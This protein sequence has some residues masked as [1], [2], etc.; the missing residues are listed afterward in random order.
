MAGHSKWK[1]IQHRKNSQDAKRGKIYQKLSKEIFIAAKNGDNPETN[2]AL[3]L[4]IDKAKTQSMPKDN[5]QRAIDKAVGSSG[6]ENYEEIIYEG[7]GPNGIAVMVFCLTDNRNRTAANVRS[8]FAK[9]GGNLGADGSVAYLFQR[10]GSIVIEKDKITENIEDFQL[11]V[12]E[13]SI[14]DLEEEEQIIRITTESKDFEEVKNKIEEFNCVPEF[15]EAEITMISDIEIELNDED[16]QVL[17]GLV[18]TLE[19]DDDV[20]EVYT[21]LK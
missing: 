19:D 16:S 2:A 15:L 1:N 21:N 12:M 17:E 13:L 18:D 14:I 11:K 4:V 7:Y 5:I 3:R 9:R 20:Q 6:S 10:K 8:I